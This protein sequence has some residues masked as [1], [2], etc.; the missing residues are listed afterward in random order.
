MRRALALIVV[1]AFVAGCAQPK[2]DPTTSSTTQAATSSPEPG[3]PQVLADA[4]QARSLNN[5]TSFHWAL[6]GVVDDYA[7]EFTVDFGKQNRC[8]TEVAIEDGGGLGPHLL[9]LLEARNSIS[10]GSSGSGSTA[11]A[12]AGTVDTRSESGGGGSSLSGQS[13]TFS[14]EQRFTYLVRNAQPSE[15]G[16]LL[17]NASIGFS[18]TCDSPFSIRDAQGG[19]QVMLLDPSNLGGGA[20]AEVF[21]VGS[22]DVLDTASKEF[23]APKVR[24]G[25]GG[26]GVHA[27][28]V[29]AAHPSGTEEWIWAPDMAASA[30][31]DTFI[32]DDTAGTVSFT[33]EQAGVYFEAFWLAAW[34]FDGPI[35]LAANERSA[36]VVE[37][38]F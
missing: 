26:F 19:R 12:H 23:T 29:T 37:S 7:L 1:C 24:V 21:L 8:K 4:K 31:P 2:S 33:V 30:L 11:A 25:A 22:A 28:H 27:A 20:G 17:G 35:D 36:S 38:P 3:V 18:V 34:G 6:D 5:L 16:F 9:S 15:H 14:G 32:V 13:G 10:W